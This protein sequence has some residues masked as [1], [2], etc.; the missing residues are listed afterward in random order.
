MKRQMLVCL[1]VAAPWTAAPQSDHRYE[2]A[3]HK[4]NNAMRNLLSAARAAE[5]QAAGSR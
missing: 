3:C 2:H 5:R 1:D 4:G